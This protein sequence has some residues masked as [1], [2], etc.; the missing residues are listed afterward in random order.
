MHVR[1]H[2]LDAAG[3]DGISGQSPI[4]DIAVSSA[5]IAWAIVTGV[6]ANATVSRIRK[7]AA[8]TKAG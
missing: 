7:N 4:N 8:S 5:D 6:V 2:S 1:A 3:R